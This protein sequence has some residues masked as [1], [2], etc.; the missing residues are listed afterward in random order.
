MRDHRSRSSSK[1]AADSNTQ[2]AAPRTR[3]PTRTSTST[4][5]VSNLIRAWPELTPSIAVSIAVP[6]AMT[7]TTA[8]YY[9]LLSRAPSPK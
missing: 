1:P 6:L 2:Y 5:T 4:S 8:H 9:C 7:L 3:T